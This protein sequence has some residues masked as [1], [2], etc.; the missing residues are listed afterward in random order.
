LEKTHK[1]SIT[2]LR[3]IFE[4]DKEALKKICAYPEWRHTEDGHFIYRNHDYRLGLQAS[5]VS[6]VH[7][8]ES[9]I[10]NFGGE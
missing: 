1:T 7:A 10:K 4:F 2:T 6:L 8:V 5:Q 9:R 3:A